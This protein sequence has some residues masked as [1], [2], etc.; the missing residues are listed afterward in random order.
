MFEHAVKRL[1]SQK[2]DTAMVGD[3]LTTDVAGA[4]AAGLWAIMVLTGI[5]GEEDIQQAAYKPDFVFTDIIELSTE[6]TL[7]AQT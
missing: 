1:G 6:L 3:R 5:S 2:M 7:A 4:K